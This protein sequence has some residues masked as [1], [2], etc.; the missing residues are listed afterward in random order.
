MLGV[1]R[2]VGAGAARFTGVLLFLTFFLLPLHSHAQ[3]E[4][5]RISKDC[6][7]LH[8]ARHDLAVAQVIDG[9]LPPVYTVFTTLVPQ[10][11]SSGLDA[12]TFS[13]RAPPLF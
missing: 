7:C 13:I 10:A 3:T 8:S 9:S 2:I 5:P 6:S 1:N 12:F 4:T 11:V